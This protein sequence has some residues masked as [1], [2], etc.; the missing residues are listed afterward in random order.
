DEENETDVDEGS[1][2]DVT[3]N[4]VPAAAAASHAHCRTSRVPEKLGR[5]HGEV[6]SRSAPLDE[7]VD[8]LRGGVG[9]LDLEA[10]DL[11]REDV[12]KPHGRDGHEGAERGGDERLGD[13]RGHRRDAVRP[14]H[15][16]SAE[17]VDDADDGSE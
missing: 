6:D 9:H 15:R 11:V 12:E 7:V 13:T 14:G 16:H 3:L 17:R 5:A 2:V 10:L 1:D 4:A 8:E